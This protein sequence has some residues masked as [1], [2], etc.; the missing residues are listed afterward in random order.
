MCEATMYEEEE[1]NYPVMT[2]AIDYDYGYERPGDYYY[3]YGVM[4]EEHLDFLIEINYNEEPYCTWYEE[5]MSDEDILA[6]VLMR[7]YTHGEIN[8]WAIYAVNEDGSKVYI[9]TWTD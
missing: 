3:T 2:Y 1:I 6:E 8:T 4:A 9:D 7:D 5:G